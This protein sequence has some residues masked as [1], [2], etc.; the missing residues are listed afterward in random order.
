MSANLDLVRSIYAQWERG[1][2]R[3]TAWAHPEIELE[4]IDGLGSGE[5]SKEALQLVDVDQSSS[6][7]CTRCAV[8]AVR[9][10]MIRHG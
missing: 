8:V 4:S 9:P 1:D 5:R 2:G 10:R 6:I 7:V 3:H